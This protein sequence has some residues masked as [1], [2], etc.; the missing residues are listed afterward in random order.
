MAIADIAADVAIQV[1]VKAEVDMRTL[2]L[3]GNLA[4]A[5]VYVEDGVLKADRTGMAG[6]VAYAE[7]DIPVSTEIQIRDE[8]IDVTGTVMVGTNVGTADE[9]VIQVTLYENATL[10]SVNSSVVSI[11]DGRGNVLANGTLT[12]NNV[13]FTVPK[14]DN[15]GSGFMY[16]GKYYA[17]GTEVNLSVAENATSI[18]VTP[19]YIVVSIE[20]DAAVQ[21]QTANEAHYSALAGTGTGYMLSK[22]GGETWTYVAGNTLAAENATT[23]L[24]IKKGYI[25]VDVTVDPYEANLITEIVD[26][27]QWIPVSE[28][29]VTVTIKTGVVSNGSY[30]L[31]YK[32]EEGTYF[33]VGGSDPDIITTSVGPI[34]E[35]VTISFTTG[36]TDRDFSLK[37]V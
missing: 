35:Q 9:N 34:E 26:G 27:K 5:A 22:D 8:D 7:Y 6:F 24:M 16:E 12:G 29:S 23:N 2:R 28:D 19:G 30:T 36:T 4:D 37:L 18:D 25:E 14:E 15:A 17:Y 11:E 10:R 32:N 1:D 20:G 33:D 3:E 31:T 13:V 21:Y